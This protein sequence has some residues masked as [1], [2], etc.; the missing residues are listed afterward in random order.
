LASPVIFLAP[1]VGN[2]GLEYQPFG[3]VFDSGIGLMPGFRLEHSLNQTRREPPRRATEIA[4]VT[5]SAKESFQS[6]HFNE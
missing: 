3:V 5:L 2:D 6:K 4:T 1:P